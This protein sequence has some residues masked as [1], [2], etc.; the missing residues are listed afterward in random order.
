MTEQEK[1]VII[2]IGLKDLKIRANN[3]DSEFYFSNVNS[4]TFYPSLSDRDYNTNSGISASGTIYRFKYGS[5][6]SGVTLSGYAYSR[7]T[8]DSILLLDTSTINSGSNTIDFGTTGVLQSIIANQKTINTG[9]Q[10]ASK[11]I[12]H[13]TNI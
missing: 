6:V 4:I 3:I 5:T 8:V 12:P 11:L 9:V 13:T 10:K 2:E 1:R 7:V